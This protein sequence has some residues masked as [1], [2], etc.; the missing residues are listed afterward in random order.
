ME[1]I[2]ISLS[3]EGPNN[4]ISIVRVDGV[5]D[6]TTSTELE[7]VMNSLVDQKRHRIIVDLAGVEYISSAGWG[8]FISNIREIRS[9]K[10]DIKLVRMIP[11]VYE[12]FELLEFDTILKAYDSL[13]EAKKD[14]GVEPS[15]EM[16][17]AEELKEE[18]EKKRVQAEAKDEAKAQEIKGMSNEDLILQVVKERPLLGISDIRKEV[19]RI[20]AERSPGWWET[21][22]ILKAKGLKSKTN[23]LRFSRKEKFI[24]RYKD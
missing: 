12:V 22:K 1:D 8:I 20:D 3:A 17:E 9:S 16:E 14:F 7:K 19:I 21:K 5:I 23:R 4:D 10:G 13:E 11:E 2:R 15:F 6:T 24:Q 18:F